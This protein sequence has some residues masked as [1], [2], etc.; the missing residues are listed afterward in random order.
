MELPKQLYSEQWARRTG[1]VLSALVTL[2]LVADGLSD[3]FAPS[4]GYAEMVAT[5]F[6]LDQGNTLGA[7]ALMCAIFYAIPQTT[8]LGAILV[9]GF[10]GG[11][12]STHLRMGEIGSIP[13]IAAVAIGVVAWLALFLRIERFRAYLPLVRDPRP[14]SR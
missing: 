4:I 14:D 5:G 10:L 13:Q 3:L 2:L 6:P 7:I 1:Y 12:I 8:V 11:A 9:T